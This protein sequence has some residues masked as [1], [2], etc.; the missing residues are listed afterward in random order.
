MK[1]LLSFGIVLLAACNPQRADW[2]FEAINTMPT[3][4]DPAVECG[5]VLPIDTLGDQRAACAFG[6]GALAAETLGVTPTVAAALP[7]R[8]IIVLMKENRSFDHLLGRLHEQGQPDT[9]AIPADYTNPDANGV[10]VAP[11]HLGN[12]CIPQDPVHQS[13][14]MIACQNGGKMDG[15]VKNAANTTATDGRWALSVYEQ[16]DLPFNYWLANT[17]ALSD[18]HF[19]PMVSGTFGNRNFMLF[20]SHA[21]VVDT[22]IVFPPPNTP[23]LLHLLMNK[24]LTWGVYSD[25]E[26]FSGA[27]NWEQ[28]DPGVHPLSELFKALKE[29]TLPNVVFVDAE[30]YIN[31][32]HP[33]A[34][35]QVGEAWTKSIYDAVVAS[36]QW[37]RTAM[38]WT[39][40][41][42]GAFFDHVTPPEACRATPDSPFTE[43]GTRVPLVM[44]S[45][46]AK[47]HYVSH[48]EH[49]HTAITRFIETVFNLPALTARDA[50]SDALLD[51]FD[52][53]CGRDLSLPAPPQPGKGGCTDPAP[54]GAH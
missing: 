31:D 12:T 30:E 6:T 48:V 7:I 4:A 9:D 23:S 33:D 34:D 15:F 42:G 39:Y 27:M 52:F 3:P 14:Q 44:I 45:P 2:G 46:W 50:N 8:H 28:G 10:A 5:A 43:M 47:R 21:G 29:G 1:Y 41:E 17:Y 20:G 49:D 25:G 24:G 38:I 19:A 54:A 32:D 40:D 36:P 16:A 51:M 13:E 37:S 35:L 53:S 26:V 22:G 18:R 11:F